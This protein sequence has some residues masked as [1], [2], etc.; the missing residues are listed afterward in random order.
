[1]T[2]HTFVR[3]G[4]RGGIYERK[5]ILDPIANWLNVLA[6]QHFLLW[7]KDFPIIECGILRYRVFRD[8]PVCV[9]C[10]LA[11]SYLALERSAA[12]DKASRT[13]RVCDDQLWHFNLYGRRE[14]GAEVMFTQDHILPRKHGGLDEIENLQ[15]M[16]SP[17]NNRKGHKLEPEAPRVLNKAEFP[18]SRLPPRTKYVGRGTIHGNA[19]RIGIDGTRDEV[20]ERHIAER[21]RD[22]AYLELVR[23]EL[24]GYNLMCHCAPKRCH[25]DWLLRVANAP[26]NS[27]RESVDRRCEAA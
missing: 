2:E 19:Y 5:L 22:E 27:W 17:C 4:K 9:T 23:R 11:G 10:G 14:D 15:T 1:M 21:S 3:N 8:N 25:A 7:D 24:A 26:E 12:Y 13:F 16:C 6:D 18:G 20:I